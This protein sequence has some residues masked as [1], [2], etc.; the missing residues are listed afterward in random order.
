MTENEK[1]EIIA[2]A[3]CEASPRAGNPDRGYWLLSEGRKGKR[4]EDDLPKARAAM[5]AMT[6]IDAKEKNRQ[7]T[8]G[9][10]L[11]PGKRAIQLD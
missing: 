7:S 5:A 9:D 11:S 4:W 3:I 6:D 10:P 2:R 8:S 1:L